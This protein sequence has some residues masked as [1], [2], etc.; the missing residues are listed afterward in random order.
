MSPNIEEIAN[1][2]R[3]CRE[4]KKK[5]NPTSRNEEQEKEE[6]EKRPNV[7]VSTTAG[8]KQK[9]AN[10]SKTKICHQNVSMFVCSEILFLCMEHELMNLL[11]KHVITT[12]S[13]GRHLKCVYQRSAV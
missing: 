4:E 13:S 6:D 7:A 10:K 11:L 8:Q 12:A 5:K 2:F 1:I 9:Q 3:R